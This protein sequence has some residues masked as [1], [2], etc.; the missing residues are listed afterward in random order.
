VRARGLQT[1]PLPFL[2]SWLHRHRLGDWGALDQED[3]AAH[4]SALG[5]GTRLLSAYHT[6][7]GTKVWVI[8]EWDR[9]VTTLLL[10]ED[11]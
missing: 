9:S 8:P 6:S 1:D 2:G 11:Y 3:W 5:E 4:D 7:E 10:P